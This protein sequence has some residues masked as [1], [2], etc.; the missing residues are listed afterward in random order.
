ML[1]SLTPRDRFLIDLLA[2]HQLLTTAQ[3]A[4]VAFPSRAMAQRRLLRLHQLR[5][6]DRFRW[7]QIV[8]S[9][10]WHYTLGA[11]GEAIVAARNGTNPPGAAAHARRVERLAASRQIDH[12]LGIN[13]VFTRLAAHSLLQPDTVLETWRS[14]KRCAEYCGAIVRPDGYGCWREG[15]RTVRFYFEYDTGSEPLTKVV[16]KL[17]GYD[18]LALA[19]SSDVLVLFWLPTARR[20]TNLQL[21]ITRAHPKV[22]TATTSAELV[23]ALTGNPAGPVWLT[24]TGQPRC[25]LLDLAPRPQWQ[26]ATTVGVSTGAARHPA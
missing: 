6:L 24:R 2:E 21:A 9:T 26:S 16:A 14:E 4:R 19:S 7:N 25:T 22:A 1:G 10:D 3:L 5:V 11:V 12:L 13:D 8:G 18:D 20:E 15:D 23:A 17:P